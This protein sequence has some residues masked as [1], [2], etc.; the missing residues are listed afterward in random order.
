M[1]ST[2]IRM[3]AICTEVIEAP[4]M[5]KLLFSMICGKAF[6]SR[7]QISKA[8]CCRTI[9]MPMAVIRGARRGAWRSGR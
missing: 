8:T 1:I 5:M 4:A 6:G 9:D 3:M 7:P 2:D